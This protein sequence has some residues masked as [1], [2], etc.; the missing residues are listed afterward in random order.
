MTAKYPTQIKKDLPN[1]KIEVTRKF[2]A[3]TDLVWRA[4]TESA[5]L[6]QWWAPKPWKAVTKTH[7][8]RE[9]GHWLYAMV[10]PDGVKHWSK[11]NY[12]KIDFQ[13]S[14][15]TTDCFCDE[16]GTKNPDMPS[17]SWN[18]T[19]KATEIGTEVVVEISFAAEADIRKIIEMGFEAGFTA[20]LGNLEQYLKAQFK[21]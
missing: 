18:N 8:F 6:E 19:F 21:R 12:H 14:F 3:S 11:V 5:L 20:A 4:W 17:M 1:K 13:K 10:S 16:Q 2:D 9:G 7:D 15:Q